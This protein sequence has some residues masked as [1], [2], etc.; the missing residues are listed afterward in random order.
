MARNKTPTNVLELRGAGKK[1]P[2]RMRDREGEPQPEGGIGPAP[3]H[4][5]EGVGQI[6]DELVDVIPAGV[7]GNTDRIALER[8]SHLLF[9]ART[10]PDLW[11]SAKEKDLISYLSRFGMTPSDRAKNSIPKGS[12]ANPWEDL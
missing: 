9:E 12:Q 10:Y 5:S 1:H 6:W 7:L 2:E 11:S 8:L 4:L 3:E